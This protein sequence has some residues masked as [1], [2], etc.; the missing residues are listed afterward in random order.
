MLI[1][2]TSV[3][4]FLESFGVPLTEVDLILVNGVSAGLDR[5]VRPGDR[6]SVYPVFE[7][8][9]LGPEGTDIRVIHAERT[10]SDAP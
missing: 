8:F 3:R 5:L 10:N 7:S 4:D 1:T 2:P 9:D 6:L